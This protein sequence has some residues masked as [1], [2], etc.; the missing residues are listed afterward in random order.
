MVPIF[1]M[2]NRMKDRKHLESWWCMEGCLARVVEERTLS[3]MMI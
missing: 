2:G 3:V 1:R